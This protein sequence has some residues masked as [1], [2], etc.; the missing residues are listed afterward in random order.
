[1]LGGSVK[2]RSSIS[3]LALKL[4]VA[5]VLLVWIFHNI[6]L[7]EARLMD[8]PK[9][10]T[11]E[12][13]SRTEQWQLAWRHG[14][15]EVWDTLTTVNGSAFA[16]SLVLMGI[17]LVVGAMRW[18]MALR[19]QGIQLGFRRTA[20]ISLIAHFFNSFLLGST[21]GDLLKAYYAARESH[22]KKAEAVTAV[23][24]DRLIGLFSMLLFA[25]IAMTVNSRLVT[26]HDSLASISLAVLGM[27]GACG[28]MV[29]IAFWGGITS[30]FPR[31]NAWI[32]RLPMGQGLLKSLE[33]CRHYGSHAG[34][35]VWS[36]ISSMVL[37]FACVMQVW[38]LS[39]GLGMGLSLSPLLVIVPSVICISAIPV[40]PSGLGVR[41]NLFVILLSAPAVGADST[42]ALSL[43][44]LA[45]AGSL[46]WSL[47]GG[48]VYLV[49]RESEHLEEIT[50]PKDPAN[51]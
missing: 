13:L 6:F 8:H 18:S 46:I 49:V 42:K 38:V 43:S 22:H 29:G 24:V 31:A 50:Q 5:T 51:G 4:A 19:V 11:W 9:G 20:E 32:S 23:F 26:Q 33:A 15:G 34:F 47:L 14:P 48:L 44:L 17:T 27:L 35:L 37:N 1:M 10:Q 36:M 39:D 21:G 7:N 2:F 12:S 40:T 16:V 41:E 28:V 45:Y 3:K 30:R 25:G